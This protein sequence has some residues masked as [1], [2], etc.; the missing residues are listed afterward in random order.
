[1]ADAQ[2]FEGDAAQHPVRRDFLHLTRITPFYSSPFAGTGPAFQLEDEDVG[3]SQAR[4][5]SVGYNTGS[6][7]RSQSPG[8]DCLQMPEV[9]ARAQCRGSCMPQHVTEAT[10]SMQ[11]TPAVFAK[12]QMVAC[13]P[14]HCVQACPNPKVLKLSQMLPGRESGGVLPAECWK[15]N[16]VHDSH[17]DQEKDDTSMP[18]QVSRPKFPRNLPHRGPRAAAALRPIPEGFTTLAV[19]NI[20]AR[21]TKMTLLE[22]FEPDGS[23][24]YFYV[25]YSFRLSRTTGVAFLNFLSHDLALDFQRKWHRRPLASSSENSKHIDVAPADIQGLAENLK[26]FNPKSL[27]RLARVGMLPVFLDGSGNCL[28]TVQVLQWSG[29]LH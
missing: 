3:C 5:G 10:G 16:S 12:F 21:Y 24:D 22:E 14:G 8:Q 29:V 19:R 13:F 17:E 20:P 26:T 6:C 28:D 25:P 1:M 4:H 23:F 15:S 2:P 11:V 7:F 9:T 27:A 18:A